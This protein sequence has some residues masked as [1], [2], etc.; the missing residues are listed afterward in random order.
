LCFALGGQAGTEVVQAITFLNHMLG[1][2]TSALISAVQR[3]VEPDRRQP[4]NR[5]QFPLGDASAAI[6]VYGDKPNA[7]A[8]C[9][10]GV[11]IGQTETDWPAAFGHLLPSLLRRAEVKATDIR[12][13]VSHNYSPSFL[14]VS[15]EMFPNA[16]F[17]NRRL[18]SDFNFG[19]ADSLITLGEWAKRT[20]SVMN[21]LCAVCFAGMFG[22]LGLLL[23]EL[24]D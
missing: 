3:V 20:A 6:S 16:E 18:Y 1:R 7:P 22:C 24:H 4:A 11:A 19:C 9:L 13:V 15:Q 2:D 12:W 10:R 17:C 8:L 23:L 21:G 5:E 14:R